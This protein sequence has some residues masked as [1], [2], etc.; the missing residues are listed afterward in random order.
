MTTEATTTKKKKLKQPAPAPANV[1]NYGDWGVEQAEA[2]LAK[3]QAEGAGDYLK[4]PL[5]TSVLR[6]L[7]P[8]S[9][10]S[11]PFVSV[12]QH[13]IEIPGGGQQKGVGFVCPRAHGGE[14]CPACEKADRLKATGNKADYEAAKKLYPKTRHFANAIEGGVVVYQL[15]Y[16]LFMLPVSLF[17][18]PMFTTAFPDLARSVRKQRWGELGDEVGR[19]GA[20]AAHA[21]VERSVLHE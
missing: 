19:G 15:A 13:F 18:V 9:G 17:A 10:R 12:K 1:K 11:S 3:S 8:A 2:D 14:R 16:V 7:P 5:G 6:F 20:R 4:L 21:H